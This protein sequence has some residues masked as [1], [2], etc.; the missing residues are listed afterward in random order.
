M[1]KSNKSIPVNQNNSSLHRQN[2]TNREMQHG[3]SMAS[4][5]LEIFKKKYDGD[6]NPIWMMK[7]FLSACEY[8]LPIPGW[9]QNGI[10]NA[11]QKYIDGSKE[12]ITLDKAFGF[13]TPGQN[14]REAC[15]L[16]DRDVQLYSAIDLLRRKGMKV[17]HAVS[18]AHKY[19]SSRKLDP[20]SEEKMYKTYY[21]KW[22]AKLVKITVP[23]EDE[24]G[25]LLDSS[26]DDKIRKKY[27]ELFETY[28]PLHQVLSKYAAMSLRGKKIEDNR[29]N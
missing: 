20:P 13:A 4:R 6:Q 21:E 17:K 19:F 24:I 22:K 29:P 5:E 3:E 2:R 10:G 16:R 1:K 14:L 23:A 11:F 18:V 15:H 26:T 12:K 27:R 25:E 28:P 9:I 7:A 8:G